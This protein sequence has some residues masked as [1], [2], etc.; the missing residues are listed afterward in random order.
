MSVAEVLAFVVVV[1]TLCISASLL[2]R[3]VVL[4]LGKY[5]LLLLALRCAALFIFTL[6]LLK[7]DFTCHLSSLKPTLTILIDESASMSLIDCPANRSRFD[8][9]LKLWEEDI[10]KPLSSRFKIREFLLSTGLKPMPPQPRRMKANGNASNIVINLRKAV[11]GSSAVVLLS[12]GQDTSA[13]RRTLKLPE[14]LPPIFAVGI[15]SREAEGVNDISLMLEDTPQSVYKKTSFTL[16]INIRSSGYGSFSAPLTLYE[17]ETA[18]LTETVELDEGENIVKLSYTPQSSGLHRYRVALPK[19]EGELIGENNE[20][21]FY[22]RVVESDI[23]VFYAEGV[24]R[25]EYKFIKQVL[26]EDPNIR[27]TGS[28]RIGASDFS[29]QGERKGIRIKGALPADRQEME[30]FNIL[31]L[32]DIPRNLL[33]TEQLIMVE[34]FVDRGGTLIIIGGKSILSSEYRNSRLEALLP[35]RLEGNPQK[36]RRPFLPSLTQ[37]GKEHPIFEGYQHHLDVTER[38]PA[39]VE[40]LYVAGVPK[41]GAVT[42]AVHPSLSIGGKPAPLLILQNYGE[43]RV[44]LV[45]TDTLW[46]WFFKYRTLGLKSPYVRFFG[47]MIRW[48][49]EVEENGDAPLLL[50][51]SNYILNTGEQLSVDVEPRGDI[52]PESITCR[53]Q[54]K[55]GSEV[56]KIRLTISGDSH[57]TGRVSIDEPGSYEVVAEGADRNGRE[58]S[59]ESSV[60]VGNPYAEYRYLTLNEGLLMKLASQ[61]GGAYFRL[62]EIKRLLTELEALS[63]SMTLTSTRP[64]WQHPLLLLLFISALGGEYILRKRRGLV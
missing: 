22:L 19:R 44:I 63:E 18:V 24:P 5:S 53:L 20:T 26:S 60:V 39:T 21:G 58:V 52:L 50:R 4:R 48:A 38:S 36:V 32:G 51:L 6:F 47:Q 31:I 11:E 42:L 46:R 54:T 40:T 3:R 33:S 45:A 57:L 37:E 61:S 17:D 27:F 8:T 34:E 56:R 12:D 7:P 25:W 49:V 41:P 59:V 28:V 43:G 1:A 16:T 55:E 35:I 14:R 9:A 23:S 29:I 2:Y 64:F 15:G 13:L 62:T 30:N 10:R